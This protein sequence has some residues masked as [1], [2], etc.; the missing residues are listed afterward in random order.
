MAIFVRKNDKTHDLVHFDL[1]EG[2]VSKVMNS[3]QKSLAK[4]TTRMDYHP[5]GGNADGKCSY[6]TWMELLEFILLNKNPFM[7]ENLL[8][9]DAGS[10]TYLTKE[11]F[12]ELRTM[13]NEKQ[14]RYYHQG[15]SS[16]RQWIVRCL[17]NYKIIRL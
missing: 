9:Y 15:K 1:N 10:K 7:V 6:L 12:N 14:K 16:N 2:S 5:K 11:A 13:R 17:K 3:F 4:P 8:E